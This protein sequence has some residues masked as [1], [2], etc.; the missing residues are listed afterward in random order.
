MALLAK[1]THRWITAAGSEIATG[2]G[3]PAESKRGATH[4]ANVRTEK[5]RPSSESKTNHDL[6]E[7]VNR[8]SET[9]PIDL[10]GGLPGYGFRNTV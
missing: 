3:I 7:R 2:F 9:T 4:S 1:V 8:Y 5:S 6:P 10:T